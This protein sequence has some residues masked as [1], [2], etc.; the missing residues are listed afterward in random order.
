MNCHTPGLR[1]F[2]SGLVYPVTVE[3]GFI[4]DDVVQLRKIDSQS[5]SDFEPFKYIQDPK[6]FPFDQ[7]VLY[8]EGMK[9]TILVIIMLSFQFIC[10][11][12]VSVYFNYMQSAK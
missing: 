1:D 7:N 9:L 2:I 3:Y 12:N 5:F 6:V 11:N 4:M 10:I 8:K